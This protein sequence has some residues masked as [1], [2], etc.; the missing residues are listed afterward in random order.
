MSFCVLVREKTKKT[1]FTV[2]QHK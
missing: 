2:V 1:S